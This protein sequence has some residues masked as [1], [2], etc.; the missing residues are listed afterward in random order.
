MSHDAPP[1]DVRQVLPGL[2]TQETRGRRFLALSLMTVA[3]VFSGVVVA[4][5]VM[6]YLQDSPT[7]QPESV[8]LKQLGVLLARNP[9][10]V[11]LKE[12]YRQEDLRVR[13]AHAARRRRMQTGPW[14]LLAGLGVLVASARWYA[15]L[16]ERL[17]RARKASER[18]DDSGTPRLRVRGVVTVVGVAVLLAAAVGVM[19]VSWE[20]PPAD[21]PD[22]GRPPDPVETR[23]N[24]P[25]F[26]GP[27]G[28]GIVKAGDWPTEWNGT[29]GHNVLWKT[30]VNLAGNSSPVIWGGRVFVTGADARTQKV[31]CFDRESGRP[32]W[33][34][35]VESMETKRRLDA[36]PDAQLNVFD[37]TGYAAS[38]P[39]T[40]GRRVYAV[41]ATGDVAA[42]DFEGK[43]SWVR[44][45]GV[46]DSAYGLS[47]SL[48]FAKD[49]VIFQFDQG[50]SGADGTSAILG[51]DPESGMPIWRTERPVGGS[52]SSPVVMNT[53]NR[54]I[55]TT[56]ADPWVIAYD[57]ETGGEIWRCEGLSG[58]VA[59]S[60]VFADGK[61]FVTNDTAQVMAIR[62]GGE[63]DVTRTHVVWTAEEGMSDAS[64]PVCDGKFFLQA[65][66]TGGDVTCYDAAGGKLLWQQDMGTGFWAS[67]TLVGDIVYLPGDDG[68]TRLFKLAATYELLAE[69][70]LGEP[71]VATPAFVDGKIY[72]RGRKH[73][74]CI[75]RK[76]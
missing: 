54:T 61:V 76:K 29:T 71:L 14:L 37:D 47:S 56:C 62:T 49:T 70:D 44:S 38:T 9:D 21:V 1:E 28:M 50:S 74:F 51:L 23:D 48:A 18:M 75:G 45:L 22:G 39:V 46:P 59:P 6:T 30:P 40:D 67:P 2:A 60:P 8:T 63:G 35:K 53:G 34:V 26:R 27:T 24:W 3:A 68:K 66:G 19:S 64:S 13:R 41:F 11:A 55:V 10:D 36:G 43:P 33:D 69:N 4:V 25:G 12:L 31:F 73:L 20:R 16:D 15:S 57:P 72:V 65:R 42:V 7:G 5:L 52:W 17:P 32:L 58:D